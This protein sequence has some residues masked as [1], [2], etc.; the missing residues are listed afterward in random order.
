MRSPSRPGWARS[1]DA[2]VA[3]G[4]ASEAIREHLSHILESALFAKSGRLNR[5]LE[6]TVQECLRGRK[7]QIGEYAIGLEVYDR[8]SSFDPRTDSIVRVEAGRLR[9]KLRDYYEG[10]GKDSKIRIEFPKGS[11]VPTFRNLALPAQDDARST[12]REGGRALSTIAVLPFRDLSPAHDQEY[13][14]DGIAEELMFALSRLRHIRVVSQTSVFAFKGARDDVREIGEKLGV[15]ALL[16]GSV[17]KHDV[18]LRIAVQ[19]V[20]TLDGFHIWSQVYDLNVQDV[21]KVQE[22]IAYS[23]VKALTAQLLAPPNQELSKS[24]TASVAAYNAYLKGRFFWNRQSEE[25]LRKAIVEFERAISEDPE[26]ARAHVGLS[27][28]YRLLEFWGVEPPDTALPRARE[29]ALRAL[30]L[31]PALA[32]AN[33][34]LAALKAV[35]DWEWVIAE[36]QF[37]RVIELAPHY[38]VAHQ[39]YA[40]MCLTPQRRFEEAISELHL[41]LDL[42]PLALWVNA[43]LGMLFFLNRDY[44]QALAQLHTTLEV[45]DHFSLAH[46]F[47]GGVYSQQGKLAEA[48][49]ALQEARKHGGDTPRILG[50]LGYVNGVMGRRPQAL[51][52]VATLEEVSQSK[53][54]SP[55]D[56]AKIYLGIGDFDQVLACLDEA[57]DQRCSRVTWAVV[58]PRFDPIRTSTRFASLRSRMNLPD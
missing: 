31:D 5:F 28:C 25:G 13:F 55:V 33:V 32:E 48:L 37:K 22:D 27:D 11:Y 51:D 36:T 24:S 57:A 7:E 29:T 10:E 44:D 19:L 8:T 58:D 23:V 45:D 52:I 6:F 14:G 20:S 53:Y 3:H 12:P 56:F 50:W 2:G 43:Q 41:A 40:T 18:K 49:Q 21:F 17:R 30:E 16:E 15:E 42:D 46:M 9:S 54:V 47:L 35:Y 4:L 39:A 26:F 34:T 38:P 1:R